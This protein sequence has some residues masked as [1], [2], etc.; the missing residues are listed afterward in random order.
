MQNDTSQRRKASTPQPYS[1]LYFICFLATCAGLS[2]T[3]ARAQVAVPDPQA[4]LR[5]LE[6]AT[7]LVGVDA[8]NRSTPEL[9]A[10]KDN[11]HID[12]VSPRVRQFKIQAAHP[13]YIGTIVKDNTTPDFTFCDMRADPAHN[14]MPR[15]VT[16]W[17][18]P[19]FW[20]T[21]YTFASFWRPNDVPVRVGDRIEQGLHL[22]QLWMSYRGRAEEILSIYPPDG[23]WRLR[24]LPFGDMRSTAYGSSFLVGPVEVQGRPMVAIRDIAFD[25]ATRTFTLN[26][27]RGGSTQIK[28]AKIDQQH[29]E[30]DVSLDEYLPGKLPFA[31]LR[32]MY[33][34]DATA[35]VARVKWRSRAFKAWGES[36]VMQFKSAR[37]V[38]EFRAGRTVPS[39]HNTSAPD[40]MFGEFKPQDAAKK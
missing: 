29:A 3:S 20:L 9:C 40:M 5:A 34:A 18:T 6:T 8:I 30:L 1:A 14:A 16:F 10:Q 31:A 35:N 4:A 21:G 26:F 22:V 11:V 27:R 38:L 12:F 32:S 37:D 39:R 15:R 36:G 24:P 33:V 28:L 2:A 23:Y 13:A 19:E 17:E 7:G 25:P